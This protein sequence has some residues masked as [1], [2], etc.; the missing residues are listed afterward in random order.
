MRLSRTS[1]FTDRRGN[2]SGDA[3]RARRRSPSVLMVE[4]DGMPDSIPARIA[5]CIRRFVRRGPS[6]SRTAAAARSARKTRSRRSIADWRRGADGLE[7][8]VHLSRDGI[9]V[10]H[11]DAMLDRTTRATG[12]AQRSYRRRARRIRCAAAARGARALSEDR[13][14]H[15]A[16]RTGP[17]LAEAVVDEVRRAGASDRVC[18]GSFSV[19]R[20]ARGARG[21]ARDCD[22]RRRGSKC[23]WRCI[24]RGAASRPAACRIRRFRFPK[25]AAPRASSRPGSCSSRTKPESPCRCG[26]WTSRKTFGGCWI[27]A[28]T[29]SFRTVRTLRREVV[30]GL[31]QSTVGS[32]QSVVVSLSHQ[33]SV[34]EHY[35][36]RLDCRL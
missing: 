4:I 28:W 35:V 10:V 21:G 34:V 5:R 13:H 6:C 29:A 9:V 23:G 20:V 19:T 3:A 15:R 16:E 12:P 33:S 31:G 14:H 26:R 1:F 32:R 11:H 17:E 7:L 18:L 22:E 8:D 30:R 25:P 27:G 24:D 2:A 36:W